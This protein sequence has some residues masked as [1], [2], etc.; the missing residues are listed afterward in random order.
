MIRA[1]TPISIATLILSP[2]GIA[3]QSEEG[4]SVTELSFFE[5]GS[6]RPELVSNGEFES[7]TAGHFL[8][9]IDLQSSSMLPSGKFYIPKVRT[10]Y[11]F[12]E[13]QKASEWLEASDRAFVLK[14][15]S[16]NSGLGE[17]ELTLSTGLELGASGIH[18]HRSPLLPSGFVTTEFVIGGREMTISEDGIVSG[19]LLSGSFDLNVLA[20]DVRVS[21]LE[22]DSATGVNVLCSVVLGAEAMVDRTFSVATRSRGVAEFRLDGD[23]VTVE[24]GEDEAFFFVQTHAIGSYEI[25]VSEDGE[26]VADSISAHVYQQNDAAGM[27]APGMNST[28]Q[29]G[30]WFET[31]GGVPDLLASP[32]YS[33]APEMSM[34]PVVVTA[35]WDKCYPTNVPP[36]RVFE[37]ICSG[38]ILINDIGSFAGPLAGPV[39]IYNKYYCEDWDTDGCTVLTGQSFPTEIYYYSGTEMYECGGDELT[40]SG[41]VTITL[42]PAGELVYDVDMTS[43][44]K[45]VNIC[46]RYTHDTSGA[47]GTM[48]L[49]SCD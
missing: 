47:T 21:I 34:E 9:R 48:T 1:L 25:L 17:A 42:G 29:L 4:T 3:S 33:F 27:P 19:E 36:T 12:S 5:E 44:W 23:A 26:V 20:P 31:G 2:L 18:A 37:D 30:D 39:G 43:E 14:Q 41:G 24:A 6:V 40:A 49:D 35:V 8:A 32:E 38:C 15:F 28:T 13:S 7:H 22:P 46:H 11:R 45:M 16:S 10:L